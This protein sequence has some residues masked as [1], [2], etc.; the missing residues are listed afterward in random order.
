MQSRTEFAG[1]LSE[2]NI[3][4]NAQRTEGLARNDL[5]L[6]RLFTNGQLIGD[7]HDVQK[8]NNLDTRPD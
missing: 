5:Y 2:T 7:L 8:T 4:K 1:R 6:R 3:L